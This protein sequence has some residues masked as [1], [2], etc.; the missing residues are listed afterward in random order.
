MFISIQNIGQSIPLKNWTF[1][2]FKTILLLLWQQISAQDQQKCESL[3]K[4]EFINKDFQL[5][6]SKAKLLFATDFTGTGFSILK[7]NH[8]FK[9]CKIFC[10][11][12][13]IRETILNFRPKNYKV[14]WLKVTCLWLGTSKFNL[15]FSRASP[16]VCLKLEISFLKFG[17]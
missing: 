10:R 12:Y 2:I 11:F 13:I 14:L 3:Y 17:L 1:Q 4:P 6:K 16:S 5:A 8:C 9:C 15:W 7:L